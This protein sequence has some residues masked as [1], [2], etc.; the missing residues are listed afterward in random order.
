MVTRMPKFLSQVLLGFLVLTLAGCG[1]PAASPTSPSATAPGP[2][3]TPGSI[4]K[5]SLE[6]AAAEIPRETAPQVDPAALDKQVAANNDFAFGVYQ[7]LRTQDGNL[8]FSPYS[9][10]E[11]L[12]MTYA[13][14]RGDTAQQMAAALH[15]MLPQEQLHP[16]F[17]ALDQ[18]LNTANDA[19]AAFRLNVVNALWGQRGFPFQPDYLN[20]IARN[21]G[22][23]IRLADFTS[24]AERETARKTIN[25]WVLE[26]TQDKIK[27]LLPE[28]TLDES[29]RLVLVN[30]IY[31]K[32]E[33]VNTFRKDSTQ[34]G[35]FTRLD[36]SQVTVPLMSQRAQW[37]FYKGDGYQALALPYQGDRIEMIV[38]LPDAGKFA[39]LEQ[40]FD[41]AELNQLL[42]GLQAS[43]LKLYLPKFQF[44]FSAEMNG[45]LAQMG[46]PLAFDMGKADFSGIYDKTK[47]VQNLF[48]AHVAHKAFVAVD[49]QGTEAA[50]ATGI[51][52]EVTSVPPELRVD[53]PFIFLI[54]DQKTGS[55]LFMGRVLN[56]QSP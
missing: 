46:M 26:Q 11:A 9:L 48:I 55:I 6:L 22:A 27:E 3:L 16:V 17:N 54:R 10:S 28:G 8:F 45:P 12:A 33:W 13:G 42:G 5:G 41:Q 35:P 15:Y 14:A 34:D 40:S 29:T 19:Q 1:A 25:D 37:Q 21:Y 51:T 30:A 7:S 44:D 53:H 52:M 20:V 56:P 2:S 50:A 23:G 36:G 32:G 39:D 38:V 18:S 4:S 43:D 31:F 47:E 49:E 24:A